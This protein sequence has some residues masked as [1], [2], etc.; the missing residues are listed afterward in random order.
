MLGRGVRPLVRLL[1][2]AELR[3]WTLAGRCGEINS[4]CLGCCS[5]RVF[6]VCFK[7]EADTD[8]IPKTLV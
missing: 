3:W 4:S 2:L 6:F 1:P 7:A 5:K 8:Q